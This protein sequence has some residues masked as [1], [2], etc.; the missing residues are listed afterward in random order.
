MTTNLYKAKRPI[1]VDTHLCGTPSYCLMAIVKPSGELLRLLTF[2]ICLLHHCNA[3]YDVESVV[4]AR[5][6]LSANL[7]LVGGTTEFGPDVKRLDLTAR[8]VCLIF[9][10]IR[11]FNSSPYLYFF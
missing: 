3:G 2:L 9:I 1:V 8:Q 11:K 7:K 5:S 4:G 10:L 6:L